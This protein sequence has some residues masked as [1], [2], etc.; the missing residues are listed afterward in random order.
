MKYMIIGSLVFLTACAPAKMTNFGKV[1]PQ[2]L[3]ECSELTQLPERN[4][5]MSEVE[6][7]WTQ[8]RVDYVKCASKHK[9][10]STVVKERAVK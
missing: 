9:E 6:R 8:D 4:L 5:S 10:L 7:F 1:A 2:V 3:E